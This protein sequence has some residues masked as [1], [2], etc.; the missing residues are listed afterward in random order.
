MDTGAA[1]SILSM[2]TVER[3]VMDSSGSCVEHGTCTDFFLADGK[4]I[5]T[6]GSSFVTLTIGKQ[7]LK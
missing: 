7:V 6:C 1:R 5:E 4:K 3:F 2:N